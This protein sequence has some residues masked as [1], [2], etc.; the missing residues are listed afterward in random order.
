MRTTRQF[1]VAATFA[2]L[3]AACTTSRGPVGEVDPTIIG[4]AGGSV[5][6]QSGALK[7]DIP[8]GALTKE[9]SITVQALSDVT[10]PA[11]SIPGTAFELGPDGLTFEKPVEISIAYAPGAL[12]SGD[13]SWLRVVQILPDGKIA[14]TEHVAHVE[15][16]GR[17]VARIA[18][19]SRYA[20]ANLKTAKA[21]IST[22]LTRITDVDVLFVIDNSGSMGE[23]QASL[24]QS[25]PLLTQRLEKAG[26]SFRVGVTSPDLGAGKFGLPSCE[27]AGGDAG[28][29]QNAPRI[30]GCVGP[31]D[32]WIEKTKDGKS[33][34]PGGDIGA[35][36]SC[37]ARLGTSGCGFEQ[38]LEAAHLALGGANPGF[39]RKD[40]ALAVI[41]VTDEDDCSA[42][43]VSLFDPS[44]NTLGPLTSFRCF[45]HGV[46]CDIKD[47]RLPGARTQCKPSAGPYMHDISRYISQ[48]KALKPSG[49]V[50]VAGIA[51]ARGP[52][53][54]GLDGANPTL[55][56]S[57]QSAG[58]IAAPPVR[59][60]AFV[61][62]F[63][64]AGKLTNICNGDYQSA[65][66]TLGALVTKQTSASW[67]LPYD[68]VDTAPLTK[69]LQADCTVV[70]SQAGPLPACTQGQTSACYRLE[71]GPACGKSST[72]IHIENAEPAA[73]GKEVF[74]I[75]L[76]P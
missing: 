66:D 27:R 52:V 51:G 17:V 69:G 6:S 25:F 4:P 15:A 18:H 42:K 71:H 64:S 46:T 37:I 23:E 59:L 75:C 11:G 13:Q 32:P 2:A 5:Q 56:A 50:V 28:K 21:T 9:A 73:I 16:D 30:A 36:F 63:G 41:Y 62:A 47:P 7:L 40:A 53:V 22:T 8:A 76:A 48:L 10:L 68:P 19:F 39:L 74:A 65:L 72:R 61:D 58:G 67:C 1:T 55:K 3:L 57:C 70:A 24:T 12:G 34:V 60:A 14:P 49:A 20:L 44:N 26:L 31:T 33:N 29:L 54:V 35:A 38:P 45:E 43:D